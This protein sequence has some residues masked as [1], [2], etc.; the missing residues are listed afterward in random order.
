MSFKKSKKLNA[1][2]SVLVV[3]NKKRHASQTVEYLEYG[4]DQ[5]VV[6][7][8]VILDNVV[9]AKKPEVRRIRFLR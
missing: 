5:A 6:V 4:Q 1:V 9:N 3:M 7:I 2:V 8:T